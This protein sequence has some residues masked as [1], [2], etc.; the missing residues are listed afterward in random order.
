MREI[1]VSKYRPE[2]L[3]PIEEYASSND[4]CIWIECREYK[5]LERSV[6][7]AARMRPDRITIEYSQY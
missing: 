2:K 6:R 4:C 7:T 5:D 1:I 3:R